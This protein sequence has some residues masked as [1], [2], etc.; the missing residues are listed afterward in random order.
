MATVAGTIYLNGCNY[1]LQYDILSQS[2]ANNTT[3]VRFYG[4]LNVTNSYINW[5]TS[6]KVWAH[7][8]ENKSFGNYFTRGSYTMVQGDYTF[9]HDNDG[10]RTLNVGYGIDTSYISGSSIANIVLPHIDRYPSLLSAPDFNDE[11][12]PTITYTKNIMSSS[13]VVEACMKLNPNDA[14]P[15]IP[16]RQVDVSSGSYTFNLTTAERNALRNQIPNSNT[17]NVYYLLR[18]TYQGNS[19]FSVSGIKTVTIVNATPTIS[20]ITTTEQNTKVSALLGTSA[21]TIVQNASNVKVDVS[22]SAT[23]GASLTKVELTHS[24]TTYSDTTSP[25]SFTV[26]VKANSFT[27]KATGSRP[28]P[29]TTTSQTITRT[30]IDY[31]PVAINSFSFKRE[32]QTSSNVKLTFDATYYQRTFGSTAN[33]PIV[34]WKKDNGSWNTLTKGTDYTVDTTNNKIYIPEETGL[35]LSNVLSYENQGTFYL[36]IEDKLSTAENNM[37]VTKGIPTMELGEDDVKVNGSFASTTARTKLE[38]INGRINNA[39]IAH[40]YENNRAHV[41]LLQATGSMTSNKPIADGYILHFSWDNDGQ[42]NSQIY[43][44][45]SVASPL[46]FRGNPNSNWN[47][48]ENIYHCKNLYNNTSGTNGTVTLSET[49]ANFTYLVIYYRND[50]NRYGSIKVYSPNSKTVNIFSPSLDSNSK[51]NMKVKDMAIS[52]T[53]MTRT[54]GFMLQALDG[55]MYYTNNNN[56]VYIVRVD[57]YR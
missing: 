39:N 41:Q 44:P 54:Y 42:Y 52:G 35:T 21:N 30:M 34:K 8:T 9:T 48:W 50:N 19:Y 45:Q 37:V 14:T 22:A 20:S 56:T 17:L 57:G 47:A 31:K 51:L 33:E 23:K 26:P 7:Y 29:N 49:A 53:S 10:N 25:Y 15:I 2:Q 6:K 13:A 11:Q 36:H 4:V 18:T 27:I 55:A 5:D 38:T 1:Q 43:F 16:Y 24:G 3:T 28:S 46:Q 32:N 12:S 40:T